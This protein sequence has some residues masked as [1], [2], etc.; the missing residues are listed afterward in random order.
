MAKWGEGDPRWIVEERPDATNVNNWHWTEKNATPWSKGELRTLL[1]GIQIETG[2]I[3][4]SI[5]SVSKCEG[6]ATANNRK[7][8]LI[9]F[10]EWDLELKWEARV[11][12]S[13]VKYDGT[14]GIPN[15]SDENKASEIDLNV[16]CKTI[17]EHADMIKDVWRKGAGAEKI[18]A[19]LGEYITKL[20]SEFSKDL[21]LPTKNTAA[22]TV[23]LDGDTNAAK[24]AM[25]SLAV[26]TPAEPAKQQ[27]AS[28]GGREIVTEVKTL[29][30]IHS[31][32]VPPQQLFD[33]F[34]EKSLIVSWT[35]GP[36][37]V[38]AKEGGSFS[39]FSGMVTGQ[40]EKLESPKQIQMRWRLRSYP[41]KHY[42]KVKFTF[43]DKGDETEMKINAT[44]VPKACAGETETGFQRYY[45]SNIGRTFGFDARLY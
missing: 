32:K 14:I 20:S 2:A 31:F 44:N 29:E 35:N 8:K 27:P 39:L 45:L 3:V 5:K 37:D 4:T 30:L 6:E 10:Y 42:A 33:V 22:S 19:A 15:L 43:T 7:A 13:A 23:K 1:E 26:Q 17:G 34:V 28:N 24:T 12:G 40:F 9:F 25:N 41:D 16:E 11:S 18:R 36:C 21:I 38:D